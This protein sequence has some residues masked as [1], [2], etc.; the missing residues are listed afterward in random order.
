MKIILI[1]QYIIDKIK[2]LIFKTHNDTIKE[3]HID[4]SCSRKQFLYRIIVI[5]C[6]MILLFSGKYNKNPRSVKNRGM[7]LVATS[8]LLHIYNNYHINKLQL[9][10]AP[11]YQP[12]G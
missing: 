9:T 8:K 6:A 5:L 2:P 12:P 4:T 7:S 3:K 10:P 11:T 1:I